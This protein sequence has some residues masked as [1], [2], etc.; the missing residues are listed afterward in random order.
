MQT[1][2]LADLFQTK[3]A[4][5]KQG[6]ADVATSIGPSF[7]ATFSAEASARITPQ[8]A[9]SAHLTMDHANPRVLSGQT[10]SRFFQLQHDEAVAL[11]STSGETDTGSEGLP[12]GLQQDLQDPNPDQTAKPLIAVMIPAA[13]VKVE[14]EVVD[15]N[16]TEAFGTGQ[17]NLAST[18]LDLGS[19]ANDQAQTLVLPDKLQDAMVYGQPAID[20]GLADTSKLKMAPADQVSTLS[21]TPP[22]AHIE[23]AVDVLPDAQPRPSEFP[24]T[25]P[26]TLGSSPIVMSVPLAESDPA[27]STRLNPVLAG[28][29]LS[30]SEA[31]APANPIDAGTMPGVLINSDLISNLDQPAVEMIKNPHSPN[32]MPL[33]ADVV[34]GQR[35]DLNG[36]TPDKDGRSTGP[37]TEG[38][39]ANDKMVPISANFPDKLSK[40]AVT[41]LGPV[42]VAPPIGSTAQQLPDSTQ[43]E[44]PEQNQTILGRGT[45]TNAFGAAV[46]GPMAQT[47]LTTLT[48]GQ[49]TIDKALNPSPAAAPHMATSELKTVLTAERFSVGSPG[50]PADIGLATQKDAVGDKAVTLLS[51]PPAGPATAQV[52]S[53][54]V[55]GALV[56]TYRAGPAPSAAVTSTGLPP[57][58][59][60]EGLAITMPAAQAQPLR[61]YAPPIAENQINSPVM[62]I[63]P[64]SS[65]PAKDFAPTPTGLSPTQAPIIQGNP[66]ASL[67]SLITN[68]AIQ[69]ISREERMGEGKELSALGFAAQISDAP[70]TQG[71]RP[72]AEA[73]VT[74]QIAQ[75]L[76]EVPN[77]APNRPIEIALNPE[78]LGRVRMTLHPSDSGMQVSLVVDRPE[79]ADLLRRNIEMLANEFRELGYTSVS[80]TFSG[81]GSG[82]DGR[83]AAGGKADVDYANDAPDQHKSTSVNRSISPNG[84]V[85]FRL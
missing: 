80:F 47:G 51:N 69:P 43:F 46:A 61:V 60:V 56:T 68:P 13:T 78:E 22:V 39:T 7:D 64:L 44:P 17:E 40:E 76:I 57:L 30:L 65:A 28:I 84:S 73:Q 59:H 32:A 14:T 85:D 3:P 34:E 58:P 81:S 37:L 71:V 38:S 1:H 75:Q 36:I 67:Q 25:P 55:S 20:E 15:P 41:T 52:A 12:L 35:I 54:P 8:P 42:L 62:Q 21:G 4:A 29:Q 48:Q 82:Q 74:R 63:T 24:P 83:A 79:T 2:S 31:L 72:N 16:L 27:I 19:K 53:S 26:I 18:P 77:L 49:T 11:A 10:D 23:S 9:D 6:K 5:N 70:A 66:N 45:D 33:A 50:T